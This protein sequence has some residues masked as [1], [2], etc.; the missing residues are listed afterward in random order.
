[1]LMDEIG[2]KKAT[3]AYW[4][5]IRTIHGLCLW[6]ALTDVFGMSLRVLILLKVTSMLIFHISITIFELDACQ[7]VE[8]RDHCTIKA[9]P[10]KAFL[11]SLCASF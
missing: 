10:S 1:M 4:R 2:L 11:I 5:T 7:I 8:I 9:P 6:T 3:E